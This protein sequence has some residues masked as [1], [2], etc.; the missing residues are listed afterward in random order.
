MSSLL[1]ILEPL[2]RHHEKTLL[3]LMKQWQSEKRVT[4]VLLFSGAAGIG[5]RAMVQSLAQWIFCERSG[6]RQ[7]APDP[8]GEPESETDLFGGG[9]LSAPVA[10]KAAP[11]ELRACNQCVNCQRALKESWVDFVEITP[12]EDTTLKIDQFRKLK[13]TLGFGSHEGSYKIVSIPNAETMTVQAANSVLKLL[14]EPPKGWIFFLTTSDA[15]LLLPTI[16]SRSQ[17]IRLLP[18]STESLN[19]M[20]AL[21]ESASETS[22]EKRA[23]V[24][25]LAQGSW[26]RALSLLEPENWEKRG[27]VFKFLED[28]APQLTPVIDWASAEPHAFS[29]LMDQLESLCG[30]LARWSLEPNTPPERYPWLNSDGRES[31]ASHVKKAVR[32]FGDAPGAR[33]FWIDQAAR[34]AQARREQ[35]APLN[36]KN[37]VQDVLLPWI[38]PGAPAGIR[39]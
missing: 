21:S 37:L 23:L 31:L 19:E 8:D 12:E 13:S 2:W 24:S 30:E 16:L 39:L 11:T 33:E 10:K 5:K 15:S 7:T 18:L 28:P 6:L 25:R 27:L 29:Q 4:P 36:K 35:L 32:A 34:I 38:L 17:Q 26:S 22:S 9:G 14:E 1:P 3:P 20:L